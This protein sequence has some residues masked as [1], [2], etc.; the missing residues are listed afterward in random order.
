VKA[1]TTYEPPNVDRSPCPIREST[2][3]SVAST[4]S[5]ATHID[6]DLWRCGRNRSV[7][8]TTRIVPDRISAGRIA[9]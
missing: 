3:T 8:S 9:W 2:A 4:P 6:A 1:S 5:S 7:T